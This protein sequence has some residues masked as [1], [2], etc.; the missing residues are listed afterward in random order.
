[1]ALSQAKYLTKEFPRSPAE[2]LGG[3]VLLARIVDKCRALIKGTN[4][5]Y[6][7][8]C[9]LDRQ[10]FDFT[11]IDA[12]EMKALIAGGAADDEIA[13]WARSKDTAHS[14]A[15][16]MAWCLDQR[17]RGPETPEEK[18][19]FETLRRSACPDRVY[20][21]TWMQVLDAEEGRF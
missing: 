12:E 18:A 14:D 13:R 19:Q 20:A 8:N 2:E 17:N 5:E 3:Y 6:N 4:G 11:G 21:R 16:L 15:D 7:Y 10:F 1:M 9:P